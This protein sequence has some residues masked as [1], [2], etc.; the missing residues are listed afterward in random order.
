MLT[1]IH[2]FFDYNIPVFY[3]LKGSIKSAK[4]ILKQRKKN[5]TFS[6]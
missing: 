2:E 1:K 6:P 3:P 4:I 5:I